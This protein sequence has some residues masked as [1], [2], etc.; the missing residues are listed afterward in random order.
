MFLF[1]IFLKE[2][3]IKSGSSLKMSQNTTVKGI[4]VVHTSELRTAFIFVLLTRM[5]WE[6]L[7]W[8]GNQWHL[9][10]WYS[11]LWRR[12]VTQ[13]HFSEDHAAS[14]EGML[15]IT[16]SDHLLQILRS[17]D[18]RNWSCFKLHTQELKVVRTSIMYTETRIVWL[19][20]LNFIVNRSSYFVKILP[21]DMICLVMELV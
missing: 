20:W 2:P 10:S 9:K 7:W 6:V 19:I 12:V 11:G 17:A 8:G 13:S 5:D 16:N 15:S 14:M 1:S 4:S 3:V 21:R 18:R